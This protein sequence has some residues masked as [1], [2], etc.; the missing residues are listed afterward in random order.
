MTTRV[1]GFMAGLLL[2]ASGAWAQLPDL[3]V[4]FTWEQI[5]E[6]TKVTFT[7]TVKNEADVPALTLMGPAGMV[8]LMFFPD[9]PTPPV[10]AEG[11]PEYQVPL[12]D[13]IEANGA[14]S[15]PYTIDYTVA[16]ENKAWAMVDTLAFDPSTEAFA[17]PEQSKDNN[18][19]SQTVTVAAPDGGLPDL[20]ISNLTAEVTGPFVKYTATVQNVGTGLAPEGFKVDVLFDSPGG[21]CPPDA[22]QTLPSALFGDVFADVPGGL[23]SGETKEVAILNAAPGAG[24]HASC[25]IVDLDSLVPESNE[26]NNTF[27]PISYLVDSTPPP[28]APDLD[29]TLFSVQALL[30]QVTFKVQVKNVGDAPAGPFTVDLY[31]TSPSAPVAGQP[32]LHFWL[33]PALAPG[34]VWNGDYT[35]S[36]APN[37]NHKAWAWADSADAVKDSFLENNLEGPYPYKVAV[38]EDKPDLVVQDAEWFEVA[39]SIQYD[40]T[41]RNTGTATATNVDVDMFFSFPDLPDCQNPTDDLANA[42]HD[43][44]TIAS[45]APDAQITL[46]FLWEDPE[47]G[48]HNGWVLIDC[49]A[50]VDEQDKT[51]NAD[52]PYIV[53]YIVEAT[54]GPDL[55][56]QD[57]KVHVDCTTVSYLVEITNVGDSAADPFQVDIFYDVVTNPGYGT[58]GDKTF[59]Y[60][61]YDEDTGEPIKGTGLAVGDSIILETARKGAPSGTYATWVVV[62]TMYGVLETDEG[63]NIGG[64]LDAVVDKEKCN[65]AQNVQIT[66]ACACGDQTVFE[67]YCCLGQWDVEP[68]DICEDEPGD[69]E[70]PQDGDQVS[71]TDTDSG[72]GDFS[73]DGPIAIYDVSGQTLTELQEGG[74]SVSSTGQGVPIAA[75]L[76]ALFVLALLARRR[77]DQ[78]ERRPLR[79]KRPH[80]RRR[81]L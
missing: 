65:C 79:F 74:C 22:W 49:L 72:G 37:G 41:I 60:G 6:S 42:P 27:G 3:S 24:T 46:T 5:P 73:L 44:Q 39:G 20:I 53:E 70:D 32:T 26:A 16:G 12:P 4:S 34:D 57:F 10:S 18:L 45:L 38:D 36:G 28:P 17:F 81:D 58:E 64:A 52:G 9:N 77:F 11:K 2:G 78:P 61:D 69:P 71:H 50:N 30:D 75:V 54:E 63:N 68:F 47:P 51:N 29:V 31:G 43:Y 19:T 13:I 66:E 56:V 1:V 8:D 33:V 76:L 23:A 35:W 80:R 40:V 55:F 67:G 48:M 7:V 25:A 62:D 14:W 15:H 59:F 21:K